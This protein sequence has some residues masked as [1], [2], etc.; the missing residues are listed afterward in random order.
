MSTELYNL[1]FVNNS[2]GTFYKSMLDFFEKD[3]YHRFKLGTISTYDR[4][5]QIFKQYLKDNN[6]DTYAISLPAVSLEPSADIDIDE[7]T[8]FLWKYQNL[9]GGFGKYLYDPIYE[10]DKVKIYPIFNRYVGNFTVHMFLNSIYEFTDLQIRSLQY[11]GGKNRPMKINFISTFM[12]VPIDIVQYEY[13]NDVLNI[14]RSLDWSTTPI[15]YDIMS[16]T[17]RNEF[18]YPMQLEPIIK[19]TGLSSNVNSRSGQGEISEFKL[20]LSFEYEIEVPGFLVIET[21]YHVNIDCN[22]YVSTLNTR[23]NITDLLKIKE[24]IVDQKHYARK[25]VL[26]HKALNNNTFD[27]NLNCDYDYIEIY[28]NSIENKLSDGYDYEINSN[29]LTI[30]NVEKDSN[31]IITCWKEL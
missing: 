22:I 12:H 13:E 23:S 14:K 6:K 15:K 28:K 17:G 5:I 2:L 25:K 8:N 7:K 1:F 11:F 21:D 18:L 26:V 19:L 30:K 9:S 27:I 20:D 31:Y 3:F 10:D 4:S 29:V 24:K 16:S